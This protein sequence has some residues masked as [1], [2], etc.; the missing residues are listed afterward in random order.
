MCNFHFF[1]NLPPDI[2]EKNVVLVFTG[3]EVISTAGTLVVLR[4]IHSTALF[5][6][7]TVGVT[8]TSVSSLK[9]GANPISDGIFF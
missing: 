7:L 6:L 9:R 8:V 2:R 4:G 1:K 3:F 5:T